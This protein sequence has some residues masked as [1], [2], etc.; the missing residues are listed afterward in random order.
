[1]WIK[2]KI[3]KIIAG[4]L[5]KTEANENADE[6]THE[7]FYSYVSRLQYVMGKFLGAFGKFSELISSKDYYFNRFKHALK[8]YLKN[9]N[10]CNKD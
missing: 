10:D 5:N 8:P 6:M 1:M 2:N 9:G 3:L 4:K 7:F